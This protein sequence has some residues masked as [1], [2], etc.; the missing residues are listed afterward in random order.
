MKPDPSLLINLLLVAGGILVYDVLKDDAT[1]YAP[2]ATEL[3]TGLERKATPD[4]SMREQL[5]ALIQRFDARIS[6]L[7]Q[8]LGEFERPARPPPSGGARP[9]APEGGPVTWLDPDDRSGETSRRFDAKTLETLRAY[10]AEIDR[11]KH[12]GVQRQLIASELLRENLGL[13]RSE[14]EA[15]VEA[16]LAGREKVGALMRK[17]WPRDEHGRAQRREALENVRAAY[18]SDI[19]CLVSADAVERIM[20]NP[21]SPA[22]SALTRTAPTSS[23]G[24]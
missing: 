14:Q 11:L 20:N 12:V 16:T 19:A 13:T 2:V 8:A 15:V 21:I 22:H 9:R 3:A 1:P 17:A 18:R 24:R 6:R 5:D 4:A 23:P 7:E 10:L